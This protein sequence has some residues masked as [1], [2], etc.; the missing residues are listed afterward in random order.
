MQ[1]SFLRSLDLTFH[2]DEITHV[3][4]VY[5]NAGENGFRLRGREDA[6]GALGPSMILL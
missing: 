1:V 2:N 6:P 3:Q 5:I 4:M